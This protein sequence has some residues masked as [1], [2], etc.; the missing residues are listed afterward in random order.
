VNVR[1][2][3]KARGGGWDQPV[4]IVHP[5]IATARLYAT[6][7]VNAFYK[8]LRLHTRATIGDNGPDDPRWAEGEVVYERG[9]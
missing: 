5:D 3:T 8:E 4:V 6:V 9:G 7:I 1:I 2:E